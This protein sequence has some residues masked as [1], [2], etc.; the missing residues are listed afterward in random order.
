MNPRNRAGPGK[1]SGA[2]ELQPEQKRIAGNRFKRV[3]DPAGKSRFRRVDFEGLGR[4][5]GG[6]ERRKPVRRIDF[7]SS[8]G[9]PVPSRRLSV[10]PV[11]ALPFRIGEAFPEQPDAGT[12]GQF[13]GRRA[14]RNRFGIGRNRPGTGEIAKPEGAG[15]LPGE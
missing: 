5:P 15:P 8:E 2:P 7:R 14:D 10:D 12:P 9:D 1:I 3:A 4:R 13:P 11:V 6:S